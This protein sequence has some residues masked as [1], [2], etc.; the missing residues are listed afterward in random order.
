[1]TEEY[2]NKLIDRC[3]KIGYTCISTIEVCK[4][5]SS[6]IIISCDK[7][8]IREYKYSNFV[9][10]ENNCINCLKN[11]QQDDREE[12][13]KVW[14]ESN[15]INLKFHHIEKKSKKSQWT[16]FYICN[17]CN[18]MNSMTSQKLQEKGKDN[19]CKYCY[20]EE[21]SRTPEELLKCEIS[22]CGLVFSTKQKLYRHQNSSKHITI[23]KKFICTYTLDDGT[24]CLLEY[25]S[26]DT[27][28]KHQRKKKHFIDKEFKYQCTHTNCSFMY[29]RLD[30]FEYHE[31]TYH[32]QSRYICNICSKQFTSIDSLKVHIIRKHTN[33]KKYRCKICN[34]SFP[35]SYELKTHIRIHTKE[36]PYLCE[37]CP[38][39]FYR[40]NARL[41]HERRVHTRENLYQCIFKDC[42]KK[43]VFANDLTYHL[44]WH[45]NETPFKCKLCIEEFHNPTSLQYHLIEHTNGVKYKCSECYYKTNSK[46]NMENH[47]LCCHT[48]KDLSSKYTKAHI[49]D[50]EVIRKLLSDNNIPIT[51]KNNRINL[52]NLDST[53]KQCAI[54]DIIIEKENGLI[55]LEVDEKQHKQYGIS[56]DVHRMC[57]IMKAIREQGIEIPVLW[58]RYNPHGYKVNNIKMEQ[59]YSNRYLKLLEVINIWEPFDDIDIEIQYMFYDSIIDDNNQISLSIHQDEDYIEDLKLVCLDPII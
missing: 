21:K 2:F 23:N 16:V 17:N 28:E 4:N 24:K 20:E 25:V 50:E 9:Y 35:V 5:T 8:H 34:K 13:F 38:S 41:V 46:N 27:L 59:E 32:N 29:N 1:M 15:L 53:D 3:N 58:I 55:Y 47:I 45:N 30:M 48:N 56:H 54:I 43:F 49:R 18:G 36:K 26:K 12:K 37:Y 31:R 39:K 44:N 52:C 19:K 6:K 22:G 7:G 42:N 14:C 51:E 10:N 33:E 57:N 40:S 11:K